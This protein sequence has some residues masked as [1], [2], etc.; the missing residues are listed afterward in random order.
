MVT[1]EGTPLPTT[2]EGESPRLSRSSGDGHVG[3][4]CLAYDCRRRGDDEDDAAQGTGRLRSSEHH[5]QPAA[6]AG[7]EPAMKES[8]EA[9][10]RAPRREPAPGSPDQTPL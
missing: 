4:A 10:A 7:V 8:E 9:S 6:P 1:V 2:F 3:V 5:A